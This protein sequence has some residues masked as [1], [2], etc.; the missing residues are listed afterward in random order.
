MTQAA[1]RFLEMMNCDIEE[2]HRG[3][4][5]DAHI[6]N[7]YASIQNALY[8]TE[9]TPD[10]RTTAAHLRGLTQQ[11]ETQFQ[12]IVYGERAKAERD[13]LIGRIRDA[14]HKLKSLIE[15]AEPS[16]ISRALGL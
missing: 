8:H 1:A 14:Y 16:A 3:L 7:I 5:I 15:D 11:Y 9:V 13:E 4:G 6:R 12:S 10:I 2:L